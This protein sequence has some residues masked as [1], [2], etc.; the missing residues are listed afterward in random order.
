MPQATQ[1]KSCRLQRVT[2]RQYSAHLDAKWCK[3]DTGTIKKMKEAFYEPWNLV[4]NVIDFRIRLR[5]DQEH[6]QINRILISDADITQFYVEQM[7]N[8]GMFKKQELKDWEKKPEGNKT[9]GDATDYFEE[10]VADNET[11]ESNAVR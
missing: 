3:L 2:V 1:E 10:I 5:D 7:M 4:D 9:F 8:S 6:L 11:Y